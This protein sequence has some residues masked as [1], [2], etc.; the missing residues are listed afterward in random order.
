[1]TTKK[2]VEILD[3]IISVLEDNIN[4]KSSL[5]VRVV[6]GFYRCINT[7][8]VCNIFNGYKQRFETIFP[9]YRRITISDYTQADA[10]LSSSNVGKRP[11]LIKIYVLELLKCIIQNK[12]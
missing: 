1:M 9:E 5:D 11:R 8:Y 12:T 2:R 4:N 7:Y 10:W 3:K 6:D